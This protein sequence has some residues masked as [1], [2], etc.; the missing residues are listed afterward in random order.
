[1]HVFQLRYKTEGIDALTQDMLE[2]G[3]RLTADDLE[4]MVNK[5]MQPPLSSEKWNVQRGGVSPHV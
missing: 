5:S 2:K 4:G 3:H 1:V